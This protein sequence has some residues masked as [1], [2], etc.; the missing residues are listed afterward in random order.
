MDDQNKTPNAI[1]MNTVIASAASGL[2]HMMMTQ[3]RNVTGGDDLISKKGYNQSFNMWELSN[4]VVA[5]YVSI[6]AGC[7]NV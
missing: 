2:T 3:W 5:G 6:S 4:S 7:N 1:V